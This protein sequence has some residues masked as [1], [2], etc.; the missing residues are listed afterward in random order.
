MAT[1]TTVTGSPSYE[2]FNVYI[3]FMLAAKQLESPI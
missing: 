2:T 3:V 1:L